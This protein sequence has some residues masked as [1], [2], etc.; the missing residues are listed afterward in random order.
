MLRLFR[1]LAFRYGNV[2]FAFRLRRYVGRYIVPGDNLVTAFNYTLRFAESFE[3]SRTRSL[4][5]LLFGE[6][7]HADLGPDGTVDDGEP[8]VDERRCCNG[9]AVA[10]VGVSPL[11]VQDGEHML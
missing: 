7:R 2:H 1:C 3:N 10:A 5:A 9:H 11:V 6:R 4:P 8:G